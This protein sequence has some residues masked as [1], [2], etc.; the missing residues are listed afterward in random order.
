MLVLPTLAFATSLRAQNIAPGYPENWQALDPREVALVPKYCKYTQIY[1]GVIDGGFNPTEIER[2][3]AI[4]GPSARGSAPYIFDSM[5]HY[6]NGLLQTN[7]AMLL[8]RNEQWKK[9]YLG[10]SLEEFNFVIDRAPDSFVLLPEILTKKGENMMRIN[11][12]QRAIP[13]LERAISLKPDYWPPYAVLADYYKSS[14]DVAKARSTLENGLAHSPNAKALKR[15]LAELGTG[16]S[17]RPE[18]VSPTAVAK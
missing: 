11:Q 1:R 7:R 14:K 2:W 16:T 9:F 15:R 6:C 17:K 4:M 10:A 8:A 13:V 3:Q 12:A 18:D 5:H